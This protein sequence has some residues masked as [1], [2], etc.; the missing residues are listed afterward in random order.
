MTKRESE[1]R[2]KYMFGLDL[3][4]ELVEEIE[5]NPSYK[6]RR[7]LLEVMREQRKTDKSLNLIWNKQTHKK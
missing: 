4:F 2:E 1:L 7:S 3:Y 6:L 5:Q